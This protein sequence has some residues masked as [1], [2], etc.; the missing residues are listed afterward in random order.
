MR[1][2]IL[3]VDHGFCAYLAAD[4]NHLILFDCGHS[5]DPVFRPSGYLYDLGYRSVQR[6]FVT[7]FDQD[8]IG[9]LPSLRRLLGIEI[10]TC[11]SSITPEQL[12]RL[13]LRDGPITAEMEKL[14]SMMGRYDS[15]P[16]FTRSF[17]R[18]SPGTRFARVTEETSTTPTT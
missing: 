11:N 1:F 18:V 8:H 13:K 2:H 10:L 14:L 7:S 3:D 17:P 6:F 4:N 16:P 15:P 5:T 9:D 12:R